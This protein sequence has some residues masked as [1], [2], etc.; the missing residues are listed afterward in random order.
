[1]L[2]N[3]PADGKEDLE[4][5][6]PMEPAPNVSP[7]RA[8]RSRLLPTTETEHT[9]VVDNAAKPDHHDDVEASLAAQGSRD[10]LDP[11]EQSRQYLSRLLFRNL[12]AWAKGKDGKEERLPRVIFDTGSDRSY[13]TNLQASILGEEQRPLVQPIPL[14]LADG[15]VATFE[16]YST[17]HLCLPDIGIKEKIEIQAL[18]FEK[19]PHGHALVIGLSDM[20]KHNMLANMV[21][22]M[23]G[24][25]IQLELGSVSEQTE[26]VLGCA[27]LSNRTNTA[28]ESR[29]D[30]SGSSFANTV[31][32]GVVVNGASVAIILYVHRVVVNSAFVN[33][34]DFFFF[35]FNAGMVGGF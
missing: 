30:N 23:G 26:E 22:I 11:N 8:S 13:T 24:Q 21:N 31:N 18:L 9:S 27:L 33:V 19:L 10:Q 34:V 1:M 32:N 29:E 20:V 14:T 4:V 2:P 3:L 7:V 35:S 6:Q 28:C 5:T 16:R 12:S 15:R 25:D 17:I